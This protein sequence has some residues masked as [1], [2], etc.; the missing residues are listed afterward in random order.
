MTEIDVE[1]IPKNAEPRVPTRYH[2]PFRFML[3][4]RKQRENP[5]K[6]REPNFHPRYRQTLPPGLGVRQ[7][8]S[9]GVGNLT[10][11][12]FY[13]AQNEI[14]SRSKIRERVPDQIKMKKSRYQ[15][16]PED[17]QSAQS[18]WNSSGV[19]PATG[20]FLQSYRRKSQ[21]EK[22]S[23]LSENERELLRFHSASVERAI[24]GY[25]GHRKIQP[26]IYSNSLTRSDN[27]YGPRY[28]DKSP[29]HPHSTFRRCGTF[30]R[31]VTLVPPHNPF[32]TVKSAK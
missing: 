25:A 28:V 30:S 26:E 1:E 16:N 19:R 5:E 20:S 18:I 15:A 7:G 24:P 31:M 13:P 17:W 29:I 12:P 4:E 3:L 8:T 23:I 2:K 11:L 32:N 27:Q 14:S 10:K 22:P 9:L 6:Y 21:P